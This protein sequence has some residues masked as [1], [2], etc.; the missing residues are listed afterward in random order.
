MP[1]DLA[2]DTAGG[3][4]QETMGWIDAFLA[5]IANAAGSI[6]GAVQS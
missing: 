3:D 1:H 4:A 5:T 2:L 6:E